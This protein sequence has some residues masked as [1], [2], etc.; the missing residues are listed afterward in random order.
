MASVNEQSAPIVERGESNSAQSLP[1]HARWQRRVVDK[2][3]ALLSEMGDTPA[4]VAAKLAESGVQGSRN[5]RRFHNPV[6]RY[7]NRNLDI[8]GMIEIPSESNVLRIV[9]QG[10]IRETSLP[11]GIALFLNQFHQGRYPDLERT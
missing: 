8:G 10:K 4:E 7:L 9:R 3:D 11:A 5:E 1:R 2:V 6:I